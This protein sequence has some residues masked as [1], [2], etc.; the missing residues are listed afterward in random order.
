M[1]VSLREPVPSVA[2]VEQTFRVLFQTMGI[3]AL[4]K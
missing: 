4:S 1:D 3:G 2:S